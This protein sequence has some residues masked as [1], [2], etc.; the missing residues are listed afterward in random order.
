MRN[1]GYSWKLQE[2]S[3]LSKTSRPVMGPAQSLPGGA[4]PGVQR[5]E[6]CSN[7]AAHNVLQRAGLV[8][9]S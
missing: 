5:R 7:C 1:P 2:T 3:L 4:F 8:W 6:V 9:T